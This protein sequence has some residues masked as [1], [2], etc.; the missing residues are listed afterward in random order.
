MTSIAYKKSRHGEVLDELLD[1]LK[2]MPTDD[3]V[4]LINDYS[5]R[6]KL[7]YQADEQIRPLGPLRKAYKAELSKISRGN[8]WAVTQ[9]QSKYKRLGLSDF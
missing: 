9:L 4:K 2:D 8:V 5:T 6:K 3:V 1:R 7:E